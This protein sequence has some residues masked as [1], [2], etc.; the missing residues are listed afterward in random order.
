MVIGQRDLNQDA[1][2]SCRL[3]RSGEVKERVT[4]TVYGV[5][6]IGE[7]RGLDGR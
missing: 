6:R 4:S 3:D 1:A 2:S 5:E 7:T